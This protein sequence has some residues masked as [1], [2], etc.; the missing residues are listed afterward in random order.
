MPPV[1]D[2]LSRAVEFYLSSRVLRAIAVAALL[3]AVIERVWWFPADDPWVSYHIDY[4]VYRLGGEALRAGDDLYGYLPDTREGTNLPFTYPPIAAVLF[5]GLSLLPFTAGGVL[6]T[7]ATCLSMLAVVW[8]VL[9]ELGAGRVAAL[10]LTAPLGVYAMQ[11]M[12]MRETIGFGQVNAILMALVAID[13]FAG[14][15]KWWQGSLVGLALAIKLTPA[16]FLAYFLMR[17]DFRALA[18]GLGS[19]LLYTGIGFVVTPRD[20]A[21]YW[22]RAL[23]D[24]RRIGE[25]S[26]ASNQAL[27]G[28]LARA[29]V[30]SSVV[31]FLLC[32]TLGLACLALMAH[33]FRRGEDAM[34]A[35]TMGLYALI[36]S[37]V[38][39][40]HHWVW[41]MPAVIIMGFWAWRWLP[42]W[43][44]WLLAGF[45]LLGAWVYLAAPHWFFSHPDEKVTDWSRWAQVAG[46]AYLWWAL[47]ALLLAG[48]CAPPQR[49]TSSSAWGISPGNSRERKP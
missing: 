29:G 23:F 48:L 39:W 20:S 9:R 17:R 16:V 18:V 5:A 44:G 25:P 13:L 14:R 8:L 26:F 21:V 47:A 7:L 22:T 43:R 31:W 6:I 4:D 36:A 24:P 49:P 2:V 40:G 35:T 3:Y 37:P 30:D 1:R 19:A 15:G 34:A 32:A 46:N 12:P 11:I 42:S 38:S 33:L 10:W 28:M 41:T 45:T 27:K